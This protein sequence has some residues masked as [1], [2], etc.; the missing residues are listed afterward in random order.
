[1]FI[2]GMV[3]I[4][5]TFMMNAKLRGPKFQFV[6]SF[7]PQGCNVQQC[8]IDDYG[9]ANKNKRLWTQDISSKKLRAVSK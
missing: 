8:I 3:N 9:D 6:S 2:P 1:M 5:C 4:Y 7:L